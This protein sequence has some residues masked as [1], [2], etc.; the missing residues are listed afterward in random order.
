MSDEVRVAKRR[1]ITDAV[2]SIVV[3][4]EAQETFTVHETVLSERSGF[5]KAAISKRWRPGG[6]GKIYLPEDDPSAA[7]AYF[8]WLYSSKI[9]SK[10]DRPEP[11]TK[12]EQADMR[13]EFELLV[14]MYVFGEKVLDDD[15]CNAVLSAMLLK[16]ENDDA[17]CIWYPHRNAIRILYEGTSQDCP[18][19]KMM[20]KLYADSGYVAWFMEDD[21][22]D[23]EEFL[24]DLCMELLNRRM[25]AQSMKQWEKR[26]QWSK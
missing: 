25:I 14:Q 4:T 3:G 8:E 9:A 6:D 22:S 2:I 26:Q 20:V 1:R 15:F 7:G 16:M 21:V 11:V 19:R 23:S 12:V 17:K 18:A 5:F 13:A 10:D 24:R